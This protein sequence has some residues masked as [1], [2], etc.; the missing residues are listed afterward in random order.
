MLWP[1]RLPSALVR[2][3]HLLALLAILLIV[4]APMIS[5]AVGAGN[6]GLGGAQDM[7]NGLANERPESGALADLSELNAIALARSGDSLPD[8]VMGV[9]C[10]YCVIAARIVVL[11]LVLL[12]LAYRPL[13]WRWSLCGTSNCYAVL[14]PGTLGARGPPVAAA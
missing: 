8:H 11:L 2:S 7:C 3:L 4:A 12:H 1:V 5:R 9:D 14:Q 13:R 6:H 10:E